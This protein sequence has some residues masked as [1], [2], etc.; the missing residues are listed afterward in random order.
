MAIRISSEPP[1]RRVQIGLWTELYPDQQWA[2]EGMA[3]LIGFLIEGAA[4]SQSATFHIV[5]QSGLRQK[6]EDDLRDLD[7][8]AGIDWVV[9]SPDDDG[10]HDYPAPLHDNGRP[11]GGVEPHLGPPRLT[12]PPL[13]V[14]MPVPIL[15]EPPTP[16]ELAHVQRMS[17]LAAFANA[18]VKVDGWLALHAHW[19]NVLWL[20][21]RCVT[22]FPD[23]ND[24][25]FIDFNE[26]AWQPTGPGT[27]GLERTRRTLARCDAAI[28]FSPHVA[29]QLRA[30][31][32]VPP[33]VYTIPHGA[34]DLFP[35]LRFLTH[36]R[37][38]AETRARAGE[39]LRNYA[40][41]QDWQYLSDFPFEEVPYIIVSTQDRR[42]KNLGA[43][44]EAVERLIRREYINIKV[45]ATAT[46]NYGADWTLLPGTI[47]RH[48]LHYD[49]L[50]VPR[51]PRYI[52]A[53]LYH[54]AAL[55]IHPSLFEGGNGSWPF[56]EGISVG[57]P[58]L[59]ARA[60]HSR[61]LAEGAPELNDYS[62]DPYD[63]EDAIRAIKK[64]LADRKAAV[65]IQL[66]AYEKLRR[67]SWGIVAAEYARAVA[68]PSWGKPAQAKRYS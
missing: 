19:D 34:P 27:R 66:G 59:Q 64:V 12:V 38:D 37:G 65:D 23:A 58:A 31:Y 22:F 49:I 17:Q 68:G 29:A 42:S 24:V 7:A 67:R 44:A 20:R 39:L 45:L 52:H 57:T 16:G 28:T 13:T 2:H 18:R 4:I 30:L 11:D 6:L 54:C 21:G 43:V 26:A 50:S 5:V 8:D 46:F 14:N 56:H 60:P 35:E 32:P 9:E 36:R 53:A 61:F 1:Q 15:E 40:Q 3:R 47:E 62:F 25:T 63:V 10:P 41:R 48:Q 33:E 51:L 55:V